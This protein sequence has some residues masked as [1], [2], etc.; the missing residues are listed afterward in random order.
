LEIAGAV[1][2]TSQ[3]PFLSAKQWCQSTEGVSL[4]RDPCLT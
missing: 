4:L 3:M 2:F 1:F